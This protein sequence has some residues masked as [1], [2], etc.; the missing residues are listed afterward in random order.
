MHAPRVDRGVKYSYFV[1]SSA[2]V[3]VVDL[4]SA[5][6]SEYNVCEENGP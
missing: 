1:F 5:Y 2:A 6:T 4:V 3:C